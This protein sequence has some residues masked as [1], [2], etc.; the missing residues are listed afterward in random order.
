MPLFHFPALDLFP[1]NFSWVRAGLIA[2]FAFTT[3]SSVGIIREAY[4][5]IL[6]AVDS[7]ATFARAGDT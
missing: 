7:E 6:A 3:Y 4:A 5:I 2:A 1:D